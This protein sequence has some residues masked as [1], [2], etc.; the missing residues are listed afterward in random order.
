MTM[1]IIGAGFG[2]LL[3]PV[4]GFAQGAALSVE[5]DAVTQRYETSQDASVGSSGPSSGHESSLER[6]IAR[7]ADGV[8][9]EY[10][11]PTDARPEDRARRRQFPMRV[12][13]LP[14]GRLRL[15]NAGQLD[16]RLTA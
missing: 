9:L 12:L 7:R 2:F 16:E 3:L 13:R 15:R 4:A 10:D 14:D 6:M 8:E 1:R 11:L 5:A